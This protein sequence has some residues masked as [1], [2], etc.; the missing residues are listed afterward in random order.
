[1]VKPFV[2]FEVM[3]VIEHRPYSDTILCFASR[4]VSAFLMIRECFRDRGIFA[5]ARLSLRL[6]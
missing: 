1:L 6:W 4:S 2:E 5:R 3:E